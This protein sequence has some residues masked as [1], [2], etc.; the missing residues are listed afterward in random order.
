M[1]LLNPYVLW[2]VGFQLSFVATLGLLLYVPRLQ[3][4]FDTLLEGRMSAS[5][6]RQIARLLNDSLLVTLAAFLVTAPLIVLYFH[7]VS[8][9][10]FLTNFLVL[11][12]QPAVMLLGGAATLLQMLAN[13]LSPVPFL[14]LLPAALAQVLAWGAYV[15]LQYTILAVQVTA[16]IPYGSFEISR[17]D[18]PLVVLLY[19]A[20]LFVTRLGVK[21]SAALVMSRV[22]VP[23]TLLAVATLFVWTTALAAPDPRTR[24]TFVAAESGDATF[25]RTGDDYRILINGTDAPNTLLA[26]LGNQLP[27]WDRRID[28]VVVTHADLGNLASLNAVLERYDVGTVL[29]PPAPARGGVSY[30]KWRELIG[31]KE[32]AAHVAEEGMRLNAGEVGIEVVYAP[33]TNDER[34]MT[35]VVLRL[36]T[37][38]KTFLIAPRLT[39]DEQSA[40]LESDADVDADVAVLPN[41][42]EEGLLERTTPETVILF[43]GRR[44]EEQPSAETLKMLE[45]VTVLRMDER[46]TTT[47]ILDGARVTLQA[48]R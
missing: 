14:G 15:C 43:V 1:S 45:G 29:E 27:P 22:W 9:V 30:E 8:L 23:I 44:P 38:G 32:I 20:L 18:V 12:I 37:N 6:A 28:L 47:Y 46:G 21:R 40:L 4:A 31:D 34:R 25:L 11:P 7:R 16:A 13:A 42:I 35:N 3:A 10:G 17:V 48:E 5:R 36:G 2:D 41:E 19:A 33:G 26:F 39:H 24:I